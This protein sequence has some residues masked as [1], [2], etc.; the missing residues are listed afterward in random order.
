MLPIMGTINDS[1]CISCKAG[2]A[3]IV[4]PGRSKR[5]IDEYKS[6]YN[7]RC[8]L[9]RATCMYQMVK[10]F[11]GVATRRSYCCIMSSRTIQD[12]LSS[13][14]SIRMFLSDA[15]TGWSKLEYR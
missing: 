5:F 12:K 10:N 2:L 1:M 8:K 7:T 6:L 3:Q 13:R 14:D 11:G 4:G 15:E 9:A